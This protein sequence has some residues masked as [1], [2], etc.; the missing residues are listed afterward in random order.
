MVSDRKLEKTKLKL[1]A[2]YKEHGTRTQEIRRLKAEI[3]NLEVQL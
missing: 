2:L 3:K 1:E